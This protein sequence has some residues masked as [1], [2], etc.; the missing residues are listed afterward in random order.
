MTTARFSFPLLLLG[1]CAAG[2]DL[3]PDWTA[4]ERGSVP[5]AMEAAARLAR[6]YDDSMAPRLARAL[7]A[8]PDRTLQLLGELSTEASAR[9]LLE[10]LPALLDG[11]SARMALSAA[12]LRRLKAATHPILDR[13]DK[14][15]P[16]AWLRALGRIWDRPLDAPPLPRGEEIDRLSLLMVVHRLALS[17]ANVDAAETLLRISDRGEL[18]D[19]LARHG[20]ER[21]AARFAEAAGRRGFDPAKGARIHE[22]LL[23]HPDGALVASILAGS[24]HAL[25]DGLVRSFLEDARPSVREAAAGRLKR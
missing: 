14:L 22:A 1:A 21:P 18:E 11:A 13:L 7:E 3:E 4:L 8:A 2:P 5:E 12:G 9:L 19:L 15:D 20:T 10:R 16:R 6:T 24:P 25:R 17:T 23:S